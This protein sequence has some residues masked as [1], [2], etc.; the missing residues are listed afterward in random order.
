MPMKTGISV[1][2][3]LI[4]T[5][6]TISRINPNFASIGTKST[7]LFETYPRLRPL[8]EVTLSNCHPIIHPNRLY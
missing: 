4:D 5:G 1:C 6:A 3:G 7:K 8:E 2:E